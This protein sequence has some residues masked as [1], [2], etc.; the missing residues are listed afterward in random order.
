MTAIL[1][2]EQIKW[3][4][5]TDQLPDADT[6]VIVFAPDADDPI[7]LGFYDGVYWFSVDGPTY[8]DDEEIAAPVTAWAMLPVGP[9]PCGHQWHYVKDFMGDP[10]VINGTQ[11]YSFY[12]CELCGEEVTQRPDDYQDPCELAAD[13]LRDRRID[14]QLTGDT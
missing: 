2:I 6:T 13:E 11:N 3:I 9:K 8:G 14:D 1:D 7:W 4:A 5:V 10:N 12:R